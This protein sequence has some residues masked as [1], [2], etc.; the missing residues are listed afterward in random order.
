MEAAVV[1]MALPGGAQYMQKSAETQDLEEHLL[2]AVN[3][4][5]KILGVLKSAYYSL[6]ADVLIIVW[7]PVLYQT[8]RI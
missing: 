5:A 3:C 8:S 7:C 2:R 4:W 1:L 6:T